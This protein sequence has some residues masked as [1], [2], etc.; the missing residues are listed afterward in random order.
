[1]NAEQFTDAELRI[2]AKSALDVKAK[3]DALDCFKKEA[4]ED[5][6]G[7]ILAEAARRF[8]EGGKS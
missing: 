3:V 2:L 4:E 1:M 6:A 7:R 5:V 8:V